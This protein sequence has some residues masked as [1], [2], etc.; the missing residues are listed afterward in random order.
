MKKLLLTCM[1]ALGITASAQISVNEGFEGTTTPAGWTYTGFLRT[2]VTG[3]PCTGTAAIRKN[4]YGTT[5]NITAN[6]VYTSANS[7]GNEIAVSFK[8]STRGFSTTSPNVSGNMRVEYSADGGTTYNLIGSQ[9][10]INTHSSLCT[11][12]SGTIAAGAVPTGSNFKF[13][14]TGNNTN[15]AD[16]YLTID[17]VVLS[18][19]ATCYAPTGLN[20][21]SVTS[22]SA[23]VNWTASTTPPANGYDVYYSDVNTAP[24]SATTPSFSGVTGLSQNLTGLLSNKMYYVWVRSACS[25]SDISSWSSSPLTFTTLCG[26][27]TLPYAQNFESVTPPAIPACHTVQNAG[28]GNNWV[29]YTLANPT[30][31]F[32]AGKTLRYSY[33]TTNA[34]NA[35]FYTQGMNLTAGTKYMIRFR[36]GSSDVGYQEKMKL[37]AGTS[38]INTAMTEIADY[39]TITQAGSTLETAYFTPTTSGTYYFGFNA[40]SDADMA[41]LYLDDISIDAAPACLIPTI[42]SATSTQTDAT[43]IWTPA[44]GSTPTGYDVYYNTTGV[45]PTD[46]TVPSFE[47][48]SGTSQLISGLTPGT[49]YYVWLRAICSPTEKSSW[50]DSTLFTTECPAAYS[51]PYSLN[52]EDAAVPNLPNCTTATS[53]SG[54]PWRI[55]NNGAANLPGKWLVYNYSTTSAANSW[56]YTAGINL[57]GGTEYKITYTYVGGGYTEKM[58]VSYGSTATAAGMTNLLNDH[59]NITGNTATTVTKTFTPTTTGVYY[60]GFNAYSDADQNYLGVDNITIEVAAIMATDNTAK[61]NVAIYPNPFKDHL[62]ISDTK[63]LKNITVSDISGRQVKSMKPAARIELSDLKSGMYLVTLHYEDGSVKSFKAIKN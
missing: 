30:F 12:F 23:T 33:N 46:T 10:E 51:V 61:A 4:L 43:V 38:P 22:N 49:N 44:A 14:I 48:V 62:N 26:V 17:D 19:V 45:A 36:V 29:T 27:A 57:T 56:F 3:Y 42:T 50:T 35:W 47:N 32:S 41:Y 40:H 63:G 39:V 37:A 54:N 31:G 11:S 60:F 9:V 28:T 2:T 21:T 24:T 7:N 58:K 55:Y 34:A 25:S 53:T 52:F 20:A 59:P 13:R 18:Q 5:T 16:W 15:A 1:I 8:Y 6:A